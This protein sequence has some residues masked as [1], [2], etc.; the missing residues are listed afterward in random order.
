MTP[1]NLTGF[2]ESA[3]RQLPRMV[4][5]FIEGGA[6]DELSLR[7]NRA[8]WE[9]LTFRPRV[10][11][12]TAHVSLATTVLGQRLSMPVLLAPTGL[13]R[14]AGP[15]G[16]HAAAA[17]TSITVPTISTADTTLREGRRIMRSNER[18]MARGIVVG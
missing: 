1:Y 12:D 11:S 10:L 15:E 3:R 16:E 17:V 4:F 7:D 13:S 6:E 5:E 18:V 8:A 2:R 9:A 14:L